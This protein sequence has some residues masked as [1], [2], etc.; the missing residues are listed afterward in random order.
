MCPRLGSE[1]PA[2]SD[3]Q[4]PRAGRLQNVCM[5]DPD[6]FFVIDRWIFGEKLSE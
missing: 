2:L 6:P 3:T 4:Q 5:N 1:P